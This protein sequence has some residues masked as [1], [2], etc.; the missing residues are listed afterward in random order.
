MQE[1]AKDKKMNQTE[2]NDILGNREKGEKLYK[3]V[4]NPNPILDHDL[5]L[6]KTLFHFIYIDF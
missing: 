3:A 4:S 2:L 6:L 5:G 1:M